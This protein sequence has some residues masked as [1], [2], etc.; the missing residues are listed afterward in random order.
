MVDDD[1]VTEELVE[2]D[3]FD[4]TKDFLTDIFEN[5]DG[6][7]HELKLGKKSFLGCQFHNSTF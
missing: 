2:E 3:Y 7:G 4:G 6:P 5:G 1:D